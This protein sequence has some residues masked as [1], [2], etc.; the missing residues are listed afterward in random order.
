MNWICLLPAANLPQGTRF[1]VRVSENIS[2]N[3]KKDFKPEIT[4]VG[5]IKDQNGNVLIKNGTSVEYNLI[6]EKS[7]GVGIP[8]TLTIQCIS[9]QTVDGN[10][11]LLQGNLME[12]GA[13]RE[14]LA[15]GLG[16][17]FGL[18]VLPLIGFAL[19][20]IKGNPAKIQ[21]GTLLGVQ[22]VE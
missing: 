11:V 3:T 1:S 21:A 6:K 9:T 14:G 16:I 17:S 13:N 10:Q 4:V 12:E 2:S 19:L 8:G 18:I 22:T 7:K 5:N 20:A 15:L